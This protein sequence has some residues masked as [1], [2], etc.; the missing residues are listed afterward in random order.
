MTGLRRVETC[1]L[2]WDD[3]DLDKTTIVVGSSSWRSM[4]LESNASSAKAST[5]SSSSANQRQPV[6][7]TVSSASAPTPRALCSITASLRT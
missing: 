2:R 1:G 4:E 5:D 6:V 3:V 7:R